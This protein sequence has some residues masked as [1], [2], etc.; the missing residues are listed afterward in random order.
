[1][2]KRSASGTVWNSICRSNRT[3]SAQH[4]HMQ[5]CIIATQAMCMP[6]HVRLCVSCVLSWFAFAHK[7]VASQTQTSRLSDT[8][9]RTVT[10]DTAWAMTHSHMSPQES[11]CQ[12]NH[13]CTTNMNSIQNTLPTPAHSTQV[14]CLVCRLQT[15][16]ST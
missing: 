15:A 12:P 10:V 1:M 14:V 2:G 8:A 9:Y 13:C 4:Q 7:R 5:Y 16:H 6:T 11:V 3:Q